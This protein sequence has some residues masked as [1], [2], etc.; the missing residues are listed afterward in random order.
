MATF[1][2]LLS[3]DTVGK[4]IADTVS[5]GD[6]VT[7]NLHDENGMPIKVAGDVAEILEETL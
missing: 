7:V 4:I 1:T 6:H 2:V 5:V 3:D